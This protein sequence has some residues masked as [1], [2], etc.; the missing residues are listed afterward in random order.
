[1]GR[2]RD[3]AAAV[4]GLPPENII[5]HNHLLGGGFGRRLK[6]MDYRAVQIAKNVDGPVKVICPRRG[7][8]ARRLPALLLRQVSAGLDARAHP[9][10][11]PA[12]DRSSVIARFFPPAFQN[13]FDGE[14]L[15][16]RKT[17]RTP[18]QTC[19]LSTSDTNRLPF[20][21][22]FCEASVLL[23]T[24]F[25][26]ESFNRRAGAVAAGKDPVAYRLALLEQHP[27]AKAVLELAAANPSLL[28][29]EPN[30]LGQGVSLQF[31][32]GTYMA[33]IADVEILR[34]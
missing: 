11:E 21:T 15:E 18:T 5:V 20:P 34:W 19:W 29:T 2:A 7:H 10:L 6:S 23:I 1:M 3:A 9:S 16:A 4:T 28:P 22:A 25:V 12:R 14:T 31:A 30:R 27:R 24:I 33:A 8:P 32:F 26:T 17:N 13:G